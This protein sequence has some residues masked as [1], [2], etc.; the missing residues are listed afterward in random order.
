MKL[1]FL[2]A[3]AALLAQD[4]NVY[5]A[6]PPAEIA[7][8]A[9]G[10]DQAG[11]ISYPASF[12][13]GSNPN[14]AYDMVQRVP[15]FTL[16]EGESNVRGY[17]GA[18]G[19]LLIDGA[20]PAS[21]TVSLRQQLS[22]IPATSIERIELI[23]GGAP[24]ID[25]QGQTLLVNVVRSSDALT[26][27]AVVSRNVYQLDGKFAPRIALEGARS[28]G[29]L[30]VEGVVAY[31]ERM[32]NE[33]GKGRAVL[34]TPGGRVLRSDSLF[35][36]QRTKTYSANGSANFTRGSET[37]R[38]NLSFANEIDDSVE[39]IGARR[40]D[41]Y[42][43]DVRGEGGIEYERSLNERLSLKL[44]GL[45]ARSSK[46]I[47]ERSVTGLDIE[48]VDQQE[49]PSESIVRGSLTFRPS[50]PLTL[51]AGVEAAVNA[52][53]FSTAVI[54]NGAPV[55]LPNANVHV[56]ENRAEPFATARLTVSP[57][58]TIESGL[59]VE[60]STIKQ[61]GDTTL[62]RT[63]T[64]AKPRMAATWSPRDNSQIRVRLEREVG[65]LDFQD[66]TASAELGL[67]TVS[68]GNADLEPERAWVLEAS[69]EQRFW[70]EGAVILTYIR[71][72]I[73]QVLD[74]IPVDGRFDAPGNIGDGSRD[75]LTI[76]GA[77]PLDR[78]M[79]PGGR[80]SGEVTFTR[81]SATDPVTG[82]TRRIAGDRP[83]AGLLTFSQ[84]IASLRSTWGLE[85][86]SVRER[87]KT[88]RIDEVRE[89]RTGA[90]LTAYWDWK[91]DPSL[92]VRFQLENLTGREIRQVRTLYDGPRATGRIEAIDDRS[93][94]FDPLFIVR[95]RKVI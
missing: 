13:A 25:M 34:L 38:A 93:L 1:E 3:A 56:E 66:F 69:L 18:A 14:N 50:D 46:T 2:A 48:T 62:S 22:R 20:R 10:A 47:T 84:D 86:E 52:L 83:I 76:S 26:T 71:S 70:G 32:D 53:D 43:D 41:I 78:L 90:Y 95:I 21:K 81:S 74:Q 29:A 61:S 54:E 33:G 23:R 75:E 51:E 31:D 8:L 9:A 87:R 7:Q 63:F 30:S 17:A 82:D 42:R 45:H 55:I 68:A 60:T 57:Q 36:A 37:W 19:N 28:F 79:I 94:K 72:E 64:F 44:L 11:V 77:V 89:T 80:L 27:L 15:G 92:A 39:L 24:G 59:R 35:A 88:Y 5:S 85:L 58:L 67:G 6:P 4:E 91:P 65:Q 16:D 49:D 12:F 40:I 73:E